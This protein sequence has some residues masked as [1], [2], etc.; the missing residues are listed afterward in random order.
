MER[1]EGTAK[2][3][4]EPVRLEKR[5]FLGRAELARIQSVIED[6]RAVL[7]RAWYDYFGD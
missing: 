1:E 6:H 5:R 4:L 3:W 7:L 2:Y